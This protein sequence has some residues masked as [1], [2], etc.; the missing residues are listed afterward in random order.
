MRDQQQ[1]IRDQQEWL[2]DMIDATQPW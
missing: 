1:Q 2:S